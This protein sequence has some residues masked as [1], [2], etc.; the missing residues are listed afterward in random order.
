[1]EFL[2]A[3]HGENPG[4]GG[5]FGGLDFLVGIEKAPAHT[6]SQVAADGGF[7][8]AHESG[9]VDSRRALQPEVHA[10][11][12]SSARRPSTNDGK[13]RII[14]T[15]SQPARGVTTVRASRSTPMRIAVAHSAAEM[16]KRRP[17]STLSGGFPP[18]TFCWKRVFTY[19]GQTSIV[20]M[21]SRRSS[22][23]WPSVTASS[24][25]LDAL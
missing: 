19:P 15:S 12:F 6:M 3:A 9:Q 1:P 22:M 24:A 20:R 8:R 7:A 21:P 2:L 14:R 5:L 16:A 25:R 11:P 23:R 18:R 13:S 4:D 17:C 10:V